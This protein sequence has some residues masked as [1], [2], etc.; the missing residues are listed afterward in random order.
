MSLSSIAL[1]AHLIGLTL[2]LGST[3]VADLTLLRLLKRRHIREEDYL[4]LKLVGNLVWIG[5]GVLVASGLWLIAIHGWVFSDKHLAKL[6]ITLIIG[7]N[8]VYLHRVVLPKIRRAIGEDLRTTAFW[9]TLG[10][11]VTS[12]AIS[13]ASWWTVFFLG[14][15]R[16]VT[17]QL[18][19]AVTFY[20]I[21][22]FGAILIGQLV[23]FRMHH[24]AKLLR[25]RKI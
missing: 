5:W 7:A 4:N 15:V 9:K 11:S 14:A 3:T 13:V 1:V 22:L 23:T 12:G 20:G 19:S 17:I 21:T 25:A 24:G 16:G 10:S 8:G 18:V 2:G 6:L